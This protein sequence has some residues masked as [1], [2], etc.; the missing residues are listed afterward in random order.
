MNLSRVRALVVASWLLSALLGTGS[1]CSGGCACVAPLP[2]PLPSDQIIEGGAQVRVTPAGFDT[3]TSIIPGFL[4]NAIAAGICI[5]QQNISFVGQLRVCD[6][7]ACSGGA[8][9]CGVSVHLDHL[10]MSVPD[11]QTFRIDA[12]FDVS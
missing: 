3:L 6:Q 8:H 7:N 10:N 12:Q 9:G 4:N 11:A 5:P 2:K 1:G